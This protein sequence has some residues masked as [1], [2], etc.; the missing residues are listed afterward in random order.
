MRIL[1]A[2]GPMVLFELRLFETTGPAEPDGPT[3][4]RHE[5]YHFEDVEGEGPSDDEIRKL[6]G[7]PD[8]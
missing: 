4:I 7:D 1:I 2:A 5:H 6:R 3:V 8:D